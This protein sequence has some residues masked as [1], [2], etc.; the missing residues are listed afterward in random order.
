MNALVND[1]LDRLRV[2]LR[3][4]NITF[5]RYTSELADELGK[6]ERICML[7]GKK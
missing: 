3:G 5:G 6:L 7:N 2:L 1:Q 4:T